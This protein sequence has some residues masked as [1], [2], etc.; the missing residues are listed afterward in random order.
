MRGNGYGRG[1]A[2]LYTVVYCPDDDFLRPPAPAFRPYRTEFSSMDMAGLLYD[3]YAPLGMVV[4][5]DGELL[6]VDVL[7]GVPVD[8]A[9]GYILRPVVDGGEEYR[10]KEDAGYYVAARRAGNYL[11]VI[12]EEQE[13][14]YA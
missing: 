1:A 13:C 12:E 6:M 14:E 9:M 2:R 7:E 8:G 5:R 11:S 3:G 10:L 4:E